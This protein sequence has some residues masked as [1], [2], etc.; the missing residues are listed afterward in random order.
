MKVIQQQFLFPFRP[1]TEQQPHHGR[2]GG[3]P[4]LDVELLPVEGR[5]AEHE[6][7]A[8]IEEILPLGVHEKQGAAGNVAPLQ[9]L[10]PEGHA[11]LP[12]MLRQVI[13][14]DVLSRVEAP[15][16]RPRVGLQPDDLVPLVC[17]EGA[18]GGDILVRPVG[19]LETAVEHEPAGPGRDLE[20]ALF[21]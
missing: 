8:Q 18:S 15:P 16:L 5:L 11:K 14:E 20:P 9:G 1:R 12:V 17:G 4:E 19:L 3:H 21:P 2:A 7:F 10:Q 13:P 6:M